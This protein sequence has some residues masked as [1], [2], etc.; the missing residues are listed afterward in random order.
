MREVWVVER[1]D[2]DVCGCGCL[3]FLLRLSVGFGCMF[4]VYLGYTWPDP[5]FFRHECSSV[6]ITVGPI[7]GRIGSSLVRKAEKVGLNPAEAR[8]SGLVRFSPR[9]LGMAM[10]GFYRRH[11][12]ARLPIRCPYRPSCSAYGYEAIKRYGMIQGT[13][14]IL[15]RLS[16]CSHSVVPGTRDPLP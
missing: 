8:P 3:D 10:I 14:I 2:E 5:F 16:R 11:L 1:R 6:V 13:R 15:H 4:V 12:S 7:G 9:R